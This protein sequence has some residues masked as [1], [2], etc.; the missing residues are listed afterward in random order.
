MVLEPSKQGR[1]T[2]IFNGFGPVTAVIVMTGET[3]Y[4]DAYGILGTAHDAI[5]ALGII[6]KTKHQPG[7]H[8]GVHVGQA[9]GPHPLDGVTRACGQAATL[10]DLE[11]GFQRDGQRPS[12]GMARYIG[13]VNPCSSQVQSC[14]QLTDSLLQR[15][16][17]AGFKPLTGETLEHDIL[18]AALTAQPALVVTVTILIDHQAIGVHDVERGQEIQKALTLVN[19]SLLD[20]P[21]CPNHEQALLLAVHGLVPLE[22]LDGLVAAYAHIQVAILRCLPE[23]LHVAR[24]QQVVASRDKNFLVAHNRQNYFM[25]STTKVQFPAHKSTMMSR[26]VTYRRGFICK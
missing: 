15:R 20:I 26:K 17:A 4:T 6:L 7:K 2:R 22:G 8:L 23:E 16:A 14:G 1:I 5:A 21:D 24:V 13:L 10:P 11:G 3:G 25:V 18:H 9:V 12:R 19:I